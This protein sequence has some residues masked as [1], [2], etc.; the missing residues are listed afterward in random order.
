MKIGIIANARSANVAVIRGNIPVK[1]LMDAIKWAET[2]R[3][4]SCP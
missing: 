1:L 2:K 4:S 3:N